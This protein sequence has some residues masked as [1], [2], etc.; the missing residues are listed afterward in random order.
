MD[1]LG[2]LP[3]G[4]RN[5]LCGKR[6]G[7]GVKGCVREPASFFLKESEEAQN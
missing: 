3:G 4:G 1:G 2:K 5:G 7:E 6:E